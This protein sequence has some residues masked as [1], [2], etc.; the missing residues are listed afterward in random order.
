MGEQ[1][2]PLREGVLQVVACGYDVYS[3]LRKVRI[4]E[5]MNI[6]MTKH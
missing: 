3:R 1:E 6:I 5:E 4:Q 2:K